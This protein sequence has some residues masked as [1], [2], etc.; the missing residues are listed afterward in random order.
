MRQFK[1][2][3]ER[4]AGFYI[5]PIL[6]DLDS[7]GYGKAESWNLY[8]KEGK[9]IYKARRLTEARLKARELHKKEKN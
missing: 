6:V 8:D 4:F 7:E 2:H 9:E 1:V 3:E 5:K